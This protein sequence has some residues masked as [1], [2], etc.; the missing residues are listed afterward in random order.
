MQ[1]FL[2]PAAPDLAAAR[3]LRLK[4]LTGER[5]LSGE[6]VESYERDTRR[7][8]PFHDR[9]LRRPTRDQRNEEPARSRLTLVPGGAPQ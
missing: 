7:S 3:Q 4:S 1:E 2:I 8:P 5:R 6:T 9:P